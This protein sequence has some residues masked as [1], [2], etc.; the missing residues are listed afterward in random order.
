MIGLALT[1]AAFGC[2]EPE[3][4]IVV[5]CF[6]TCECVTPRPAF[7]GD[8]CRSWSADDDCAE[9]ERCDSGHCVEIPDWWWGVGGAGGMSGQGG[10]G[11]MGGIGGAGGSCTLGPGCYI[12]CESD[13]DCEDICNMSGVCAWRAYQS[14]ARFSDSMPYPPVCG[15]DCEYCVWLV[16]PDDG[17]E[18]FCLDPLGAP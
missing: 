13:D 6:E 15:S 17:L 7:C 5:D 9:G 4:T 10:V 18:P 2:E 16:Q 12:P 8:E 3:S 11:G 1:V 14:L